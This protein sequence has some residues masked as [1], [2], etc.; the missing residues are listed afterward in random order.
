MVTKNL[1]QSSG[2]DLNNKADGFG[3]G[4]DI[5]KVVDNSNFYDTNAI[6][7]YGGRDTIDLTAPAATG[8]HDVFAG[9]GNDTI[10][11]GTGSDLVA[12]GA[13]NDSIKL[14]SNDDVWDVGTGNDTADGG[15]GS[16]LIS[17]LY[18]ITDAGVY[19]A[20]TSAIKIDLQKTTAQFLG[21]YGTDTFR[22][23]EE[24]EGS[25]GNDTIK[26]SAAANKLY[27]DGGNDFI[28]GRG[29]KD[30]LE[31]SD[32]KDT[33]NGGAGADQIELKDTNFATGVTTPARDLV[34][35]SSVTDSGI[36]VST[37]DK[38]MNFQVGGTNGDRIDLHLIDADKVHALDQK[39]LFVTS[40]AFKS[41]AGEVRLEVSGADTLVHIDTDGDAADEM[42]ILISGVTNLSKADFIL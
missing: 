6:K 9:A 13:G 2:G 36:S 18:T 8:D 12:D 10:K 16:D 41:A 17:F 38:V 20:N 15:A 35:Y 39:F 37:R 33:I 7:T 4:N 14:G 22:N 28:F 1:K 34:Q 30:L 40:G 19:S 29:G 5:I 27:G 24:V 32:G 25:D 11:G 42:S 23:F 3:A 31:G 21:K 26:G